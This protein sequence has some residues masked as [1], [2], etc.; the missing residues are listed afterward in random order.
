MLALF[1]I[2][3]PLVAAA[4]PRL[5]TRAIPDEAFTLYGYGEGLGGLP[6]Y[7]DNGIAYIGEV[8]FVN[9]SQAAQVAF[10]EGTTSTTLVA[11]PNNTAA[12]TNA[13][14][15]NLTYFLPGTTNTDHQTGFASN[16]SASDVTTG[17][18]FYGKTLL[19]KDTSGS[20]QS[21]WYAV[22]NTDDI[23]YQLKWNSTGADE[24]GAIS[25]V[26]RSVEPTKPTSSAPDRT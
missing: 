15:S 21:L 6:V 26:L 8:S 23:N 17:F 11:N 7:Y 13:T 2:V 10:T 25:I 18:T 24:D 20:L 12:G 5:T 4:S 16:V 1:Y 14:W 3:L 19:N 22:Q 9:S